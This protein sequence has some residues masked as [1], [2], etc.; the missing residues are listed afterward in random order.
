MKMKFRIEGGARL[1]ETLRSLPRSVETRLLKDS[2]LLASAPVASAA[3]TMAPREAGA[4][5]LAD[6]ISAQALR[7]ASKHE[8]SVAV[9]PEKGFFYYGS[10]QELGT[11]RHVAQPYLAPAFYQEHERSLT[12]LA[13]ELWR[14]IAAKVGTRGGGG[15]VG[16]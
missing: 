8:A 4:P 15:G 5:D 1:A 14:S 11:A 2:L 16:L 13:G 6:H 10:F 7:S 3:S 9:G 12:I